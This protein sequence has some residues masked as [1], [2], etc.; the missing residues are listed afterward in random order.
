MDLNYLRH[1]H[2]VSLGMAE[3]ASAAAPRTAL[4]SRYAERIESELRSNRGVEA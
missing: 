4:A 1:R 2:G 3:R